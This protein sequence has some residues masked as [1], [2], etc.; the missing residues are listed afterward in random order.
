M[1]ARTVSPGLGRRRFLQLSAFAAGALATGSL[2]LFHLRANAAARAGHAARTIGNWEDLYRERW[3]WDRI[4]KGSH[5]WANCRSACAW[6][7]YVK[8]DVV[9]REEQSAVY[10]QSEPGVPDFNP[11]GCQKG[12]CYSELMYGPSRLTVPLKRVGPRGS[13]Q[14]EKISWEQAIDEIATRCVDAA[15][16]Y[17]ADCMI[18]DLGPNFDQGASTLGRFKFLMQSGGTFADMWAEIGD[19]NLGLALTAGF[20]HTG[21]SS[22]EWFLS[23]YLV[24]WM[25]NP[26]VTQM[27][28]VHFLYEARYKGAELVVIDPQ[29]TATAVHAD[30]WLPLETATDAALAL[31]TARHIIDTDKADWA[32]V[33]EQ[34]DLPLLVRLDT[35]EFLREADVVADGDRRLMY[36][37]DAR[38]QEL[39]LALGIEGHDSGWLRLEGIEPLLEGSFAVRLLD[40]AEVNVAP[41]MALLRE[42]LEAW[43]LERTAEV[44]ALHPDVILRFA[45]GFARAERPLI[46]S[47]WGSNRFVHSDLMNRAKLLCLALKGAIG[48]RGAGI[49]AT[50]F[51][52][53][54]G[55]GSQLQ[56]EHQGL[57]GKLAMM[58][59][60]L[61]P[62]DLYQIAVD[63]VTK[64]KSPHLIPFDMARANESKF[65][66]STTTASLMY[67]H[68]G[69]AGDLEQEAARY[70]ERSLADYHREAREQGWEP[71]S[72]SK[73]GPK[74]LFTGGANLLRRTNR[75]DRMLDTFWPNLDLAVCIDVKWCFT[76][77]HSDYVLPAAGWYEK[78]GIKYAVTYAPYLHYCDAAV[79][80]LGE[81]KDEWEM[82][83]LLSKR[84]EEICR[85][86]GLPAF[87]SCR[88][89]SNDW[90]TLH[91]RYTSHGAFG[92]KDAPKVTQAVLDAS[93]SVGGVSIADLERDGISKFVG[94]GDNVLPTAT[95]NP[96]WKGEGVLSTLTLF[97]EHKSRWPTYT[98]R[99]QFY[100]DHP[101]FVAA[102]EALPT[103]KPSPKAGGDHP[104]QMV[105]CHARW[106]IHSQWRDNPMLLRLQRGEP[107][108]L[109][110]PRDGAE[111]GIADGEFAELSNDC[112]RIHMRIK[113]S[114]M[115]RPRVA[116]YFHAWEPHQFPGHQS[117]KW[118]IPGIQNPLHMAGGDGQL[119]FAI[120]HLQLGSFVQD[121]RVAIRAL[122]DEERHALLARPA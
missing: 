1:S 13:G 117:F 36:F 49:H 61:T 78:V 112:G 25:H 68:Q 52:D 77:M 4:V 102:G 105:S 89:R 56:M 51:F 110:N 24:V 70:Y 63:L 29:Y 81:S 30:Q 7:I 94:T 48:K 100:L 41:V 79:P 20:A 114:T 17:G 12:A 92:P 115:V 104:F 91:Q 31:F 42:Q 14:W 35:G 33:K 71:I 84:I 57:R 80:P 47:S 53:L 43:T 60:V 10:A 95:F 23:D 73:A 28:D 119:R 74:V 83:W 50:G 38:T 75:G 111:L 67:D 22:D 37:R 69:I 108:M 9:V 18:Q 93:P 98:G 66:C 3:S 46:L 109:L 86:R 120:N 16:R 103:H 116:Y 26:A 62:G 45:E 8:N 64:R 107:C 122:T 58:A 6:D 88:G 101:W 40:G 55:F 82:F 90:K 72:A 27:P 2:P 99:L 15:S 118:I 54:A 113:H 85:E 97:T 59:G 11:R 39:V 19:L 34:T 65:I 5:G 21:G 76:A 32:Y 44:T 96:D 121:T 87:D 106:S